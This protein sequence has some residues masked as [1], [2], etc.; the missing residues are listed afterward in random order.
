MKQSEL[1]LMSLKH[2]CVRVH[3]SGI[4]SRACVNSLAP[5][6]IYPSWTSRESCP[7]IACTRAGGTPASCNMVVA[8]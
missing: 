8:V 7:T 6:S 2:R 4:F 5:K 3:R 1:K